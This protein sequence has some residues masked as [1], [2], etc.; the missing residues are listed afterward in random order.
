MFQHHPKFQI[1]KLL[2]PEPNMQ[3]SVLHV[4]YYVPLH[5]IV[6]VTTLHNGKYGFIVSV[7]F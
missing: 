6:S 4:L 1:V 5:F 7:I 3:I 2:I